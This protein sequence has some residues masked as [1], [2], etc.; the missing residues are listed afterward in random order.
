MVTDKGESTWIELANGVPQGSIL[1]PL[2]FTILVSDI[3]KELRF[4]KYHLYADDTQLYISG[5]V[6]DI[7]IIIKNINLDLQRISDFSNNNCL[8]L[9]EGKSV[10]II[11]GSRKNLDKLEELNL[12]PIIINNKSIKRETTVKNL[13]ILFDETMS[14]NEEINKCISNG[15]LKIKQAYR[16]KNFLSKF[17]KKLLVQSYLLSQFTYNSIILQNITKAQMDKIQKFQNTCV[18]FVLN[19]KKFD[20]IS[21]GYKSLSF[22]K[23]E[24]IARGSGS[25]FNA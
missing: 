3:S 6:S 13:G 24:S 11:L 21:E 10:Y 8:K 9:N 5:K 15:Y 22:F 17:S 20:H 18:R 19:L 23:N 2:L 12:P 14:W 7:A 25:F 4:C 16:Y 1:G